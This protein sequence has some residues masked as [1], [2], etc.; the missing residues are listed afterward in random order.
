[1]EDFDPEAE[2]AARKAK[3]EEERARKEEEELMVGLKKKH[4]LNF[5]CSVF[6]IFNCNVCHIVLSQSCDAVLPVFI[7]E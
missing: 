5:I 3:E 4:H 7:Y 6:P 1:M 2:E